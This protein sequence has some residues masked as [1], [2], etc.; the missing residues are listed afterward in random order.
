[1]TIGIAAAVTPM[2]K[3]GERKDTGNIYMNLLRVDRYDIS[4]NSSESDVFTSW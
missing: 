1:M 4:A 3:S 2:R